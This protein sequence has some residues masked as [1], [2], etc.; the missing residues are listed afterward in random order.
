MP[1]PIITHLYTADPA[2]IVHQGVVY[3]YTGH[4]EPPEGIDDYVMK[5][6]R[7]FSSTNMIAW[8]EHPVPLKVTDF[9]WAS[10]DAYASQVIERNGR[11]YW[12]VA[13]G[14][15]KDERG[16]ALITNDLTTAIDSDMDDLDPTVII[17]DDGQAFLFWG[18]RQCYYAPLHENMMELTG[19]I[20]TIELPDFSEGPWIHKRNDW[21]YLSYGY[22]HPERVA[23]AMSRNIHGPWLFKG[24]LNELVQ[25][26]ETNSPA[27]LEFKG[28]SYFIYHNA[29]LPGGGSHRRSVCIDY[30]YY[31]QDETMKQVQMTREGIQPA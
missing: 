30:L 9:S 25:N 4:D 15:F 14:R 31:N 27:I 11:F 21:Y 2:A 12:Y 10:G 6:W 29:G 18:N 26:C 16:T 7:C 3:L 23:Y 28:K 17:D 19:P 5:D 13:V 22:G 20:K 8:K 1:N 24:I